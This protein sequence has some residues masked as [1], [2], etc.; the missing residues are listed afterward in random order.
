MQS[1]TGIFRLKG[2]VSAVAGAEMDDI[3]ELP[4]A[5]QRFN[6]QVKT[7]GGRLNAVEQELAAL[8]DVCMEK[9]TKDQKLA[10][11]C[12]FAQNKGGSQS[13]TVA[14]TADEIQRCVAVSRWNA[15][16]LI[17]ETGESLNGRKSG[18]RRR[19]RP[20][21]ASSTSRRRCWSIMKK[22]TRLRRA[23][24]SSS[25]EWLPTRCRVQT[26]AQRRTR[27]RLGTA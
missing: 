3:G 12:S 6:R 8:G 11:I 15:Y 19:S 25:Q 9:T 21:P 27:A 13:A 24:T 10:A 17:D 16:D 23:R 7:H 18:R 14:L 2:T 4:D 5:G 22:Y 1:P 20:A 26:L